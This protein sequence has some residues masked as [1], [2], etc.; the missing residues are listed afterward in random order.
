MDQSAYTRQLQAL[1]PPGAA[2][3][4][5]PEAALTQLLGGLAEEFARVDARAADLVDEADPR[6]TDELL[7]DWERVAG[8]PD[9]CA[10][11]A[12]T[13]GLRRSALLAR[14]T[15]RGGA[16]RT[17]FQDLIGALG[18]PGAIVEDFQPTIADLACADDPLMDETLEACADWSGAGDALVDEGAEWRFT[19]IATITPSFAE[20][21]CAGAGC[22][23]DP[24]SD[25]GNPAVECLLNRLRPGHTQVRYNY[26]DPFEG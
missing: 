4:R 21:V 14:L 19:W 9:P 16:S 1:L 22:A 12:V 7:A 5:E 20:Q 2:W 11:P 15:A 6:T 24:L 26:F 23:D 18:Y 17:Y 25:F 8:L 10:G 3:P 13:V